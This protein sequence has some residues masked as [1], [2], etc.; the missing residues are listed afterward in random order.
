MRQLLIVDDEFIAVEGIK[1]GVNW[2]EIGISRLFEAYGPEQAKDMF[3]AERIDIMLCDIEMPQGTGLELLEWVREHYPATETIFLT[4]HADFGYAKQAIH[5][6]SLDYLLKPIPYPDLEEA[7]KRAIRKLDQETQLNEFSRYGKYWVQHQPMLIEK[8]WLD[9]LRQTIPGAAAAVTKAAEERNIPYSSEMTFV[10]VLIHVRR[11]HKEMT[12]QDEKIMEYAIRKSAEELLLGDLEHGIA[13][14]LGEGYM[15]LLLNG[16]AELA[17]TSKLRAACGGFVEACRAYFYA[18]VICYIGDS[19]PGHQMASM[20]HK[21]RKLDIDNVSHDEGVYSL[22]DPQTPAPLQ[23]PPDMS[24]W[25][26]L[27]LEGAEHKLLD[28]AEDYLKQQVSLSRLS[29]ELLNRFIQDFN[30]MVY[31]ALQVKGIQAHRLFGDEE[32]ME[33][34]HSATR[35]ATDASKWIRHVVG[36]SVQFLSTIDQSQ[37]LVDRAKAYIR[38]H[39]ADDVSREDIAG[40]V[41]LNPDYLTRIFKKETGLSVSDYILRQRLGIAAELLAGTDLPVGAIAGKVGY[42][43]FS[44]F[45]RMFKKH[46]ECGPVEYRSLHQSRNS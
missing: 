9:I 29:A 24:V 11:W 23:L 45:S 25:S 21:L 20:F 46:Y 30:Q 33:L 4:C 18:G 6:G 42:A 34:H 12:I 5:L 2:Q 3:R 17:E 13:I 14:M 43:N 8:F 35:S 16:E 40:H 19:A 41:F 36:K 1:S 39:L 37:S 10:A 7:I 31:Y 32:S 22:H 26:V 27:L 28:A 44:H 38:E 15:L